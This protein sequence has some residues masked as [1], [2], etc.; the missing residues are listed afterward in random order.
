MARQYVC[1]VCDK[2]HEQSGPGPTRKHCPACAEAKGTSLSTEERRLKRLRLDYKLSWA[3][4]CEL[5]DGQDG[6]CGICSRPETACNSKTGLPMP[7][8]VDHDRACCPGRRSCGQCVRGLLCAAC[9][10]ELGAA[11]DR[12]AVLP[13]YKQE[14]ARAYLNRALR[15]PSTPPAE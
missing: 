13:P 1:V 14:A 4:Y 8:A 11:K 6:L 2:Q 7:L 15:V 5:V 3:A 9:N 10:M 12:V